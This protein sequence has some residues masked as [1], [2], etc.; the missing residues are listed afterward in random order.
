MQRNRVISDDI[1]NSIPSREG[2]SAA[3]WLAEQMPGG[4]FI[5][6]ADESMEL[7]YVNQSTCEIFGCDT[8]EEFRELVGNNF[9]GMVHPDD[10]ETIQDSID[11]QIAH[12]SNRRNIDYVVYRIIRKDGSIRWVDDYG[13]FAKL[14]GY[15]DV[16]YVFIEDIT[17]HRIA[18]EEKERN[19]SLSSALEQAEAANNSKSAFLSNM[20]HEIRT[21]I[22]AILGMN[23][24]IQRETDNSTILEYSENIRKAGVSLLGII[25]DIL[26]FSKIETGK[27]S[28]D[29]EEYSTTEL[30]TDLYNL[31]QFRAEAKGLE[32]S[33]HVDPDMPVYLIGDEIRVKQIVTNILTNA[34]KYTEKGSVDFDITLKEKLEDSVRFTV[35][36]KDTGIG[37]R[38]EDMQ[39][40]FEPFDRLDLKKTK[41][42]EGTGLGLAITR[43][44]LSLM[45]SELEVESRYEKGSK[46]S[47][48]LVQKVSDWIEIGDFDL[49]PHAQDTSAI[50]SKHTLFTAPGLG[51]LVVDDTPMNLQV[52]A[53]LLKRTKIHIDVATSGAE[54]IEKFGKEHYD[55]VFLDYRMPQMNG[56]ETLEALREK[57]P[58]KYESTPI[59]SLTASA[60]TGDK[61]KMMKAGF[62]D[63]LSKP[64][65][66]DEMER[67]MIRY[68]PQDSV[69]LYDGKDED[70]E[71]DELSKLPKVIF[72]Y[73]EINPE[74]GIEYCGDVEDY[75][76]AIETYAMS[77]DA[78]AEQIETDFKN[79]DLE[80]LAL[81]VHSLK[82]TSAAIGACKLSDKAKEIELGAKAGDTA[83]V[84]TNIPEL[85]RDYRALKDILGRVLKDYEVK[86]ESS[87]VS[88]KVVEEERQ[89]FLTRAL[90]EAEK[91]NLAK[92]LFLSNVSH[93]IRTP[94]N[95]IVGLY[96]I[97]LQK[98]DLDDETRDIIS[99]IGVCVRHTI[100]LINDIL[101]MSLI[102]SGN[103]KLKNEEFSFGNMLE[104]INTITESK[105]E[106]KNISFDCSVDGQID[107]RYIGD[108]LKIKQV[109]FN[110]IENAINFTPEGGKI[111]FAVR[112]ER[113]SDGKAQICME[114]A[115]TGAG[116]DKEFMP[117]LFEPFAVEGEGTTGRTGLGLAIT[118]NIVEMMGGNISA[119]SEKGKGSTFTVV[120]PLGISGDS[121]NDRNSFDPSSVRALI[122]DDDVTA[123]EHA[124]MILHRVGIESEYVL[125]GEE[126]LSMCKNIAGL[127]PAFNLMLVDWKMPNMDG[128]ELT[129]RIREVYSKDEVAVILTT[130]N[131]YEVMEAAFAAGVNGFLAKPMFA[132]NIKEELSK[133]LSDHKKDLKKSDRASALSG[134]RIILAEDHELN[135][136]IMEQL[137]RLNDIEVDVAGD[138]EEA[139]KLFGESNPGTYDAILMDIRM[140]KMNG[141]EAT[142]AIRGLERTDAGSI[143]IIA[144]TAN[145]LSEDI[146]RSFEAG[147]NAHLAKPIEPDELFSV[148]KSLL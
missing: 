111:S 61:E 145:A 22:T 130:Y 32:L 131:W 5:Y 103:M 59:I 53:G 63:Y 138:G 8:V 80:A 3:E 26:D 25:S 19:R 14:P 21:P 35:S 135:V 113:R 86:D 39:R 101:E 117:H 55:L 108:D 84:E 143:P 10:Y 109:L 77:I 148:L 105:C 48:T 16:Y 137:L 12:P 7:L 122:V 94:L 31:V 115:D 23:E 65:N 62:T 116:I 96:N 54:C 142:K 56:I 74:K 41:S 132:G 43:Q 120:I 102:E 49:D 27:M 24:M 4:F 42:I 119:V 146:R 33:F 144:L 60:V 136:R 98:K 71:D 89:L 97:A 95:D 34:V 127:K 9:K 99:H 128:I 47:F 51:I 118:R 40:L 78:K 126:A 58:E 121:E 6:R 46:F 112:E 104:Q 83:L 45:G 13:H 73:K 66:I 76:F 79:S 129:R 124:K 11:E 147:M 123:C 57:Y 15:G 50:K 68:L 28:L 44:L 29:N 140:P 18:E 110:I 139:L 30:A 36:V 75:I 87:R 38:D 72:E 90:K 106:D 70:A 93:E 81:N 133:I 37:I 134:K 2:I 92:T 85:L 114:V 91:A 141:L 125:S 1:M 52:I 88:L 64:V 107:E 82:S 20:S 69:I 67:M 17:E 100:S